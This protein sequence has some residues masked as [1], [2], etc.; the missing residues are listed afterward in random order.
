MIIALAPL[1]GR[2][3]ILLLFT[4]TDYVRKQ[5][6]AAAVVEGLNGRAALIGL[7]AVL[8]ISTWFS[9]VGVIAVLLVFFALRRIMI[10]RLGGCTGDTAGA[11]VEITEAA[12]L[13]A[14]ALI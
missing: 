4:S 1:L 2:A 8:L 3:I 14:A 6:L 12:W 13:C 11:S 9:F 7:I 5:G 10:K